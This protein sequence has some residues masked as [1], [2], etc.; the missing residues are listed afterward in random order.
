MAKSRPPGLWN[1]S[2]PVARPGPTEDSLTSYTKLSS[3]GKTILAWYSPLNLVQNLLCWKKQSERKWKRGFGCCTK[4]GGCHQQYIESDGVV[5]HERDHSRL[6]GDLMETYCA[7]GCHWLV[8]NK[9]LATRILYLK[10]FQ[11]SFFLFFF[12]F[13][14]LWKVL[15]IKLI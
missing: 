5:C 9:R 15:S 7:F 2:V 14:F 4:V 11:L 3:C 13:I 12:I 6:V 10:Y 1:T 8:Q